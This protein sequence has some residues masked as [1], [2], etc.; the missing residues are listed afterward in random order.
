MI[1][2]LFKP[3]LGALSIRGRLSILNYHQVL[4]EFDEMRPDEITA[5]QFEAQMGWIADCFNVM[6]VTEAATCLRR[7]NLPARALAITFDD[8]YANNH[9]VAFPILRKFG[10]KA[11]F[12]IASG[13]LNG[14]IMW[15]DKVIE[16]LRGYKSADIDLEWLDMGHSSLERRENRQRIAYGVLDKIKH[17]GPGEREEA[18]NRIV[19]GQALP[20]SMMMTAEHVKDLAING[21]EIGGHTCTHPILANLDPEQARDEIEGDKRRLEEITGRRLASFAYPNGKPGKDYDAD[22]LTLVRE[23]GYQQAVSMAGGVTDYSSDL[24]QMRRFTPWRR[25]A[26]GFLGQLSWNYLASAA[27]I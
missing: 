17:L 26:A 12:F 27:V 11:T 19:S 3:L 13:Y 2:H 8:G 9:S 24:Y 20:D 6:T 4:P 22:V 5:A 14:G 1:H 15:N 16:S 10:L 18:V 25:D 21:M 23:A 7:R